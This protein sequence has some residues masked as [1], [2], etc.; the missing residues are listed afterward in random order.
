MNYAIVH[1]LIAL[2]ASKFFFFE[3]KNHKKFVFDKMCAIRLNFNILKVLTDSTI[4]L[5]CYMKSSGVNFE[6]SEIL[7]FLKILRYVLWLPKITL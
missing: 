4:E 6:I 5:F 1:S 7:R 2:V 3:K